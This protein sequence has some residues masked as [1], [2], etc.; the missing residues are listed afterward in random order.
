MSSPELRSVQLHILDLRRWR[1]SVDRLLA[2][3]KR[4]GVELS[5]EFRERCE[6]F[7][8][9]N[10]ARRAAAAEIARRLALTR[11]G[12]RALAEADVVRDRFGKPWLPEYPEVWFNMSHSGDLA[13]CVVDSEAV[14]VDVEKVGPVAREVVQACCTVSEQEWIDQQ[15]EKSATDAFHSVWTL[16]ES[17]LKSVGVGLS[18]D[19][20][21]VEILPPGLEE[22]FW[23][24]GR[25]PSI[26]VARRCA[27]EKMVM[28]SLDLREGYA[29]GLTT[30]GRCAILKEKCEP[31]V[32]QNQFQS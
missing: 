15:R 6:R 22:K 25:C 11:F 4:G 14:G 27:P 18:V 9:V 24:P 2:G 23:R 29:A 17:Y 13:L 21:H 28:Q 31:E 1:P 12:G 7:V 20:R 26:E 32:L 10:D 3:E 30:S 5:L 19:P 16:K 8:R